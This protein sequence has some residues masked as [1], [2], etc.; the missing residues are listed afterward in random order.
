MKTEYLGD[1][2]YFEDHG[3]QLRLFTQHGNEVFLDDST[4]SCFFI[5]LQKAKN[6]K[7]KIEPIVITENDF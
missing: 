3:F 5:H 7:I 2:L 1:G 4:L 6:V